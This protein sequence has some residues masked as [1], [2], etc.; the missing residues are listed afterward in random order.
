MPSSKLGKASI[1]V[2]C[3]KADKEAIRKKWQAYGFESESEYILFVALNAEIKVT[4]E[5]IGSK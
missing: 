5:Q 1:T 4:A 2:R 3:T